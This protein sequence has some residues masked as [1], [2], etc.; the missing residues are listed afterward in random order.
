MGT[1]EGVA[2]TFHCHRSGGNQLFTYGASNQLM[3]HQLCLDVE[4]ADGVV[5]V[6]KSCVEGKLSQKWLHNK[7]D[8][9]LKSLHLGRCLALGDDEKSL[10]FEECDGTALRHQW[11]MG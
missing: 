2:G 5:P 3:V 4:A 8:R 6:F 1:E 7:K 10:L 11:Q 9:L